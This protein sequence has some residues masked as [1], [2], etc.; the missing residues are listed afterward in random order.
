[1]FLNLNLK[2]QFKRFDFTMKM[3]RFPEGT[4]GIAEDYESEVQ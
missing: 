3:I 4:G 1:M 2:D